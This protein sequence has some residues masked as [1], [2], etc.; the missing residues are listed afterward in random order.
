MLYKGENK[1]EDIHADWLDLPENLS[2]QMPY[3]PVQG[4]WKMQ[5]EMNKA[6]P[7][8]LPFFF[9]PQV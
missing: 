9:P 5:P 6:V 3:T 7:F 2:R 8:F 4:H 1:W